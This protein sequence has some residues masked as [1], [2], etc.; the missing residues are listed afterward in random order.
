[1]LEERLRVLDF[2]RYLQSM[3][4]SNSAN[5]GGKG[6]ITTVGFWGSGDNAR[7]IAILVTAMAGIALAATLVYSRR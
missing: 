5:D 3:I 7:K 1:M 2:G 4:F 6:I